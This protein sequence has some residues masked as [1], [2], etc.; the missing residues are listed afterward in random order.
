MAILPGEDVEAARLNRLQTLFYDQAATSP[1]TLTTTIQDMPGA[2]YVVTTET[3][4][5][6]YKVSAVFDIAIGTANSTVICEG[7]LYLDGVQQPRSA[8]KHGNQID[9][10]TVAQQWSGTLADADDYEFTLRALKSANFGAMTAHATHTNM[11]IEI[12]EVA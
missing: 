3:D 4:N 1:L 12:W 5:A 6:L 2:V 11:I 9:R 10:A 7:R 8:L